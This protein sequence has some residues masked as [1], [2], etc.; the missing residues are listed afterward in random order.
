MRV[1]SSFLPFFRVANVL[2]S[3]RPSPIVMDIKVRNWILAMYAD[4]QDMRQSGRIDSM[5]DKLHT[6]KKR[7]LITMAGP[8][9][10]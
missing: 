10:I 7:L 3:S 1:K 5:A 8:T 2:N 6:R 4:D 9:A